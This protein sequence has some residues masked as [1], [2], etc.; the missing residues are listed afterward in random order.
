MI[1]TA[2]Y[3][4]LLGL[5]LIALSVTVIRHR[6]RAQ[7]GIGVGEDQ[8]LQ[9][10]VR[11]HA[12]FIEYTPLFLILLLL[13]EVVSQQ[14]VLIHALGAAFLIGRI[15]HAFGLSQSAGTSAPRFIGMV[16][17]FLCIAITALWLVIAS[18]LQLLA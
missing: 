3:A 14:A 13:A 12:N 1:V 4:G 9:R 7:I 5:M 18:V 17:T 6:F 10:A 11:V 15:S 2:L 16:L 8:A